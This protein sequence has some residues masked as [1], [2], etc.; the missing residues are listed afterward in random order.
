ML[1]KLE[2]GI[3]GI[4]Y[5]HVLLAPHVKVEE[6]FSLHAV[7]DIISHGIDSTAL[8]LVC[9]SLSLCDERD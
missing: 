7:R 4:A 3:L 1:S 9:P 2:W 8:V 6:T 5:T